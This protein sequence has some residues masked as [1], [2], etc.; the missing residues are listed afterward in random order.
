[1]EKFIHTFEFDSKNGKYRFYIYKDK[2]PLPKYKLFKMIEGNE[3]LVKNLYNELRFLNQELRLNI[4]NRP[5]N[6]LTQLNSREFATCFIKA[7][8]LK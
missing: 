7:L 4:E 3:L 6:R 8:T 1:M 5:S 2:N